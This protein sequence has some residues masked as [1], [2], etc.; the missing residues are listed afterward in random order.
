[1]SNILKIEEN[2]IVDTY[3][4]FLQDFNIDQVIAR[5]YFT[6]FFTD[7]P[8]GLDEISKEVGYSKSTV[9]NHLNL[10]EKLLDV[11]RFKKPGSKK[12]YFKCAHNFMEVIERSTLHKLSAI[13]KMIEVTKKSE[14]ELKKCKDPEC[15][16][17]L[18]RMKNLRQ[19]F[20]V[21]EDM[22]A[23]VI[24]IHDWDVR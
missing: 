1:M 23:K 22:L 10:L 4:S 9:L 8:V 6:L 14:D 18:K 24:K 2:R 16:K 21:V 11:E 20:E 19:D 17:G 5:I 13:R 15:E 12:I 7:E 3:C